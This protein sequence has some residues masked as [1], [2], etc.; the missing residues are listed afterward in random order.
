MFPLVPSEFINTLSMQKYFHFLLVDLV[1]M[2]VNHKHITMQLRS[3]CFME[4]KTAA[5]IT[6][7]IIGY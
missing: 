4:S 3:G 2:M 7:V 5:H 1:I 6:L